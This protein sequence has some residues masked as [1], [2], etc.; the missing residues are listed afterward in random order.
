VTACPTNARLY[1]DVHDPDSEV[2]VAIRERGGYALMPEW[3]TQPANHYLPRQKTYMHV[4]EEDLQRSDNPLTK[5]D[6]TVYHG[7]ETME[8]VTW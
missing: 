7:E 4:T 3:G 6:I 5:E 8:D 2:S 1:G